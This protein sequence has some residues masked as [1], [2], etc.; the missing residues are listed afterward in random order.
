MFDKHR[1]SL[2]CTDESPEACVSPQSDSKPL[3]DARQ[4]ANKPQVLTVLANW[5]TRYTVT[6]KT[7]HGSISR[8]SP[9]T[10]TPVPGAVTLLIAQQP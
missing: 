9:Y 5:T 3:P 10:N 8:S 1:L 2:H 4:S 7:W 6:Q